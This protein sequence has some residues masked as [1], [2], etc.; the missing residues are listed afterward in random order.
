MLFTVKVLYC[1]GPVAV[2]ILRGPHEATD[3]SSYLH[4]E[5]ECTQSEKY[6]LDFEDSLVLCTQFVVIFYLGTRD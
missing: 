5:L 1:E 3:S 2:V 6:I 4:S